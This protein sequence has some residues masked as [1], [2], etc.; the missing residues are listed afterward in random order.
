M[1]LKLLLLCAATFCGTVFGQSTFNISDNDIIFSSKNGKMRISMCNEQMFRI[2]KI[3]GSKMPTNE[4]WMVIKY[5]FDKVKFNVKG[6]VITTSKLEITVKD[7]PWLIEVTDNKGQLLYKEV[8]SSVKDTVGKHCFN[9]GRRNISLG[10]V[11]A[12]IFLD[13]R[14]HKLHLNVETRQRNKACCRRK[15]YT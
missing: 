2:T 14:G 15:G 4:P 3:N 9:A 6:N 13:Q 7:N 11:S 5:H 1:K 10:L 8:A 12:W